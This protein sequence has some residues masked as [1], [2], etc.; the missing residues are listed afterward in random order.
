MQASWYTLALESWK[1]WHYPDYEILPFQF[2]VEST[3]NPGYAPLLYTCTEL[4]LQA[5]KEGILYN[6]RHYKGYKE[7]IE[8]YK[9]Y[10]NH[11]YEYEKEIQIMKGNLNLD[12]WE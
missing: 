6:N 10:E 3:K 1:K 8:L 2:V 7:A 4:D 11:S 9:W 5:G 12:L